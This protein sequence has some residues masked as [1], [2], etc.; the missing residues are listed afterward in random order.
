MKSSSIKS[1]KIVVRVTFALSV[2]MVPA[3]RSLADETIRIPREHIQFL[4]G[5]S[6]RDGQRTLRLY[7]VQSCLRGKVYTDHLGRKQDCGVVSAAMLAAVVHDT[8]PICRAVA[9]VLDR[10]GDAIPTVIVVCTVR[11]GDRELDLGSLLI[12]QGFAFAALANGGKPVYMPYRTQE[13]IA[14]QAKMGL[15]AFDDVPLPSKDLLAQ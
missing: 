6:W 10:Q 13:M 15:W 1:F 2:F 4:T 11:V 5:D 7:G 3:V 12:T 9:S 8:D 14:R